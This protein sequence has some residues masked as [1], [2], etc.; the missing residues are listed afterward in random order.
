MTEINKRQ[1]IFDH[2]DYIDN[3]NKIIN[4]LMFHEIKHT[5]NNNG[6]FVNISKISDELIDNLYDLIIELDENINDNQ[7]QE[8]IENIRLRLPSDL[9]IPIIINHE[10]NLKNYITKI[11]NQYGE[12]L[13]SLNSLQLADKLF[14]KIKMA[15]LM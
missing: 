1:Y 14:L 11:I 6:Y 15:I 7:E 10:N 2:I 8:I 4:F 9:N 12:T 5:I 3:H 13:L